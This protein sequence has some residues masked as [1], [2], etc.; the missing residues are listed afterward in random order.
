MSTI[1]YVNASVRGEDSLSQRLAHEF[2]EA[3]RDKHPDDRLVEQDLT[4]HPP[5]LINAAFATGIH[6]R[7]D[8]YT[9]DEAAIMGISDAYVDELLAADYVVM[10]APIYNFTLPTALKAYIDLNVRLG[11]T[12]IGTGDALAGKKLLVI[13][14][15]LGDYTPGTGREHFDFHEPYMR[16]IFGRMGLTDITYV[17]ATQNA[18]RDD[19]PTRAAQRAAYQAQVLAVVGRWSSEQVGTVAGT[20]R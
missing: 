19:E 8:D 10:A 18:M 15:R 3:W 13:S 5:P 6:K 11:R 4:R 12:L 14:A 9:P 7:P 2:L 1:L 17:A 20:A 16:F